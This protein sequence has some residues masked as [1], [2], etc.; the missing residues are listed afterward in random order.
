M[1]QAIDVE[2][3]VHEVVAETLN[4][5]IGTPPDIHVS[6]LPP[7]RGDRGLLRQVWANLISN[8]IKYSSKTAR[9]RIEITGEATGTENRYAVRDNGVGFDMDYV[10]KLFGVFQRLHRDDEFSG[11][12]VG[13]AIV[14]RVVN[15]HGGRVWAEGKI[16]A[17]AVF[18]F[19]LPQG[20]V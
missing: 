14:Q 20:E 9:P 7:A 2:S 17:G 6:A 10:S 4:G 1:T 19:A 18:S 11:T 15:R 5:Y 13:L 12:G 8:A 3:L 16:G